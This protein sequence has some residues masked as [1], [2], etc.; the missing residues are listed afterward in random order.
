VPVPVPA[1][2]TVSSY[3]GVWG[4]LNVAVTFFGPSI[5][6]LQEPVPEHA[7]DQPVKVEPAAD[8]A[9]SVTEV[10]LSMVAEQ[11]EGQAIPLPETL[12]PP[13][14]VRLTESSNGP[15]LS[16]V[17]DTDTVDPS[18][19]LKVHVELVPEQSPPQ[20]TN[21]QPA[22]GVSVSVMSSSWR[23][24]ALHVDGQLIV[25]GGMSLSWPVTVPLPLTDT[26]T[27]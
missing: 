15:E 3:V 14:P 24:R 18:A 23:I 19:R 2:L 17:A 26:L 7:P 8:E 11:V 4:R 5:V 22:A 12:P 21:V 1:L 10:P 27:G 13:F 6:K 25:C 20:P 9:V 16:K